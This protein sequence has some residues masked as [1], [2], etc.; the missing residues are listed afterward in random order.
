MEGTRQTATKNP[1]SFRP[2]IKS[3]ADTDAD[4]RVRDTPRRCENILEPREPSLR[5]LKIQ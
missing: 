5:Q 2:P 3:T 4:L 1:A